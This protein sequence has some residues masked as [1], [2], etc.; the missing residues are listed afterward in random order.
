MAAAIAAWFKRWWVGAVPPP[1]DLESP[2]NRSWT[3]RVKAYETVGSFG[4]NSCSAVGGGGA[5]GCLTKLID[6]AY[7][8]KKNGP[9]VQF[10]QMIEEER[11]K[12]LSTIDADTAAEQARVEQIER[13]YEARLKRERDGVPAPTTPAPAPQQF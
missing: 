13:E 8:E 3:D 11:Q 7:A 4:T 10:G 5:T 2:A 9:D 1:P 6:R 12:R